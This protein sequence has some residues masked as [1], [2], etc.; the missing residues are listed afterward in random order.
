[1]A[2]V[3]I[4]KTKMFY[5]STAQTKTA[6]NVVLIIKNAIFAKIN[7]VLVKIMIVSPVKT[8]IA[9]TV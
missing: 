3:S 1:M 6:S 9:Q 5:A 7:M 4:M 2:T 8:H